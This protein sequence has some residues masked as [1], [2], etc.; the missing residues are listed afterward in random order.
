MNRQLGD[1]EKN[2]TAKWVKGA[3]KI[4]HKLQAIANTYTKEAQA[5]NPGSQYVLNSYA[6]HC[7]PLINSISAF[8]P[9]GFDKNKIEGLFVDNTSNDNHDSPP[10]I[11][12]TTADN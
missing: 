10:F 5:A 9:A 1:T 4:N 8:L 2:K 3:D 7:R 12:H 11:F 6:Y